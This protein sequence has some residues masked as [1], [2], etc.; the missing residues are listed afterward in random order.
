MTKE[1]VIE[2]LRLA[3]LTD[4]QIEVALAKLEVTDKVTKIARAIARLGKE[5][6]LTVKEGQWVATIDG[7]TVQGT[8]NLDEPTKSSKGNLATGDSAR[9]I[10]RDLKERG[11]EV[12]DSALQYAAAYITRSRRLQEAIRKYP[13]LAERARKLG[14]L[15]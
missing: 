7:L 3:G 1:K 15:Q 5:V 6:T 13:D 8:V 14:L 9:A 12:T 11:E 2:A 4:Q 10:L